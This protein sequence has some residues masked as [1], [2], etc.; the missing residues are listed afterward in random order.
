V[1]F[2]WPDVASVLAKVD[3]ERAELGEALAA[4]DRAHVEAELGDLLLAAANLGRKLGIE[5][6]AALSSAVDRFE[7][8]FRSL[9]A[10]A[11]SEGQELSA[12]TA[13]ELDRRWEQAKRALAAGG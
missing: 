10:A 13:Q 8:R 4:A 3:E 5:P 2:D 12:L 1:G 7:L 9:E 6:E 11:R